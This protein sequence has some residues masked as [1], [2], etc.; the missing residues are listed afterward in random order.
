MNAAA[1]DP[2]G[3]YLRKKLYMV[4]MMLILIGSINWLSI[5]IAGQDLVRL[6]L[7]PRFARWVY[8]VI[9]LA[10]VPLLFS[11]DVYLPFLGETLVPGAALEQRTPQNANDQVSLTTKPGAKVLYWT[12]EPNPTQAKELASWDVAYNGYENSGVA[13]ADDTG[14]AILRFRGP[15]Q[16][17]KVP[18][19]GRLQPHIHFRVA[20]AN[21]F[22]GSVQT[23]FLV[24]GRVEGFADL[25]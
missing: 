21:G 6:V 2:M 15:P 10:A 17:Y 22:M 25:L 5:G 3:L 8:I 12:T 9:G 23:M 18:M 24:D 13:V 4:I 1:A 7:A 14:K 11:R 16:A 20:D 19:R